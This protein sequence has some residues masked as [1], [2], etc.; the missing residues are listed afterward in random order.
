MTPY[1]IKCR[2]SHPEACNKSSDNAGRR[3]VAPAP[4][5]LAAA[6]ARWRR[7]HACLGGDRVWRALTA[8]PGSRETSTPPGGG[9]GG[10][11]ERATSGTP[12]R[13]LAGHRRTQLRSTQRPPVSAAPVRSNGFRGSG[14]QHS[15][16]GSTN[17][18]TITP[19]KPGGPG[20]QHPQRVRWTR[21]PVL[22]SRFATAWAEDRTTSG[23]ARWHSESAESPVAPSNAQHAASSAHSP[24]RLTDPARQTDERDSPTQFQTDERDGT[25]HAP[26]CRVLYLAL[27]KSPSARLMNNYHNQGHFMG[28]TSKMKVRN[29]WTVRAFLRGQVQARNARPNKSLLTTRIGRPLP[30]IV[31]DTDT[32]C[33]TLEVPEMSGVRPP[34]WPSM[35]H[36]HAHTCTRAQHRRIQTR[37]AEPAA[38]LGRSSAERAADHWSPAPQL[39][40]GS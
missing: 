21:E 33:V 39:R 16:A 8:V 19:S 28:A 11:D 32:K 22:A 4:L 37:R 9:G 10:A 12:I 18:G 26:L 29:S 25:S 38:R 3:Q 34:S 30:D 15:P 17:Q 27:H 24:A 31:S 2:R 13:A 20:N 36:T 5:R 6:V 35:S 7:R 1:F 23:P 40:A 14:N